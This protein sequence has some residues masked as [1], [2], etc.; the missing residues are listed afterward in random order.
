MYPPFLFKV[1]VTLLLCTDGGCGA[2]CGRLEA[3][4]S[5]SSNATRNRHPS[6]HPSS[7]RRRR[8]KFPLLRRRHFL[9]SLT[10]NFV[11]T[12]FADFVNTG[13]ANFALMFLLFFCVDVE[14]TILTMDRVQKKL[15]LRLDEAAGVPFIQ[16]EPESQ[17]KL[18]DATLNLER[19]LLARVPRAGGFD[20]VCAVT[21]G[22]SS[23]NVK[24]IWSLLN[25]I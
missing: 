12:G 19:V 7:F 10:A 1:I 9:S 23:S 8:R 3:L 14:N 2:T 21:L 16:I 15:C 5:G 4:F 18:L 6:S 22:D 11:N 13:F 24:K 25:V 17:T 20:V